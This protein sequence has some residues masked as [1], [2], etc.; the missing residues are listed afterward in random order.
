MNLLLFKTTSEISL[1]PVSLKIAWSQY[2][3]S[4]LVFSTFLRLFCFFGWLGFWTPFIA[5]TRKTFHF[6]P[7]FSNVTWIWY[8]KSFQRYFSFVEH[9]YVKLWKS[10]ISRFSSKGELN[11]FCTISCQSW[12]CFWLDC[13]M[14]KM[15]K[16]GSIMGKRADL[17]KTFTVS[18][19]FFL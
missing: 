18:K 7:L 9:N 8:L 11:V 3:S 5:T 10:Q 17:K 14:G 15:S 12:G 6:S 16:C 19:I 2:A 13:S 4:I 1:V